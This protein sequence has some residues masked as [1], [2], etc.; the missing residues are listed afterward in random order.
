[1]IRPGQKCPASQAPASD[2]GTVI[3]IQEDG[4]ARACRLALNAGIRRNSGGDRLEKNAAARSAQA[5]GKWAGSLATDV[6]P[7][8]ASTIA[9]RVTN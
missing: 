1:V 8:I 9:N 7:F 3:R 6:A 4:A 2:A 5:T